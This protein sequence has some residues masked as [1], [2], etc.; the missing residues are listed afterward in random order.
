LL[1]AEPPPPSLAG[2]TNKLAEKR[3][4]VCPTAKGYELFPKFDELFWVSRRG[5]NPMYEQPELLDQT[6]ID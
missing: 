3:I 6:L 5:H 4:F 1:P 2:S